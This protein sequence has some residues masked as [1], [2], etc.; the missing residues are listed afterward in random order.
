MGSGHAVS[1]IDS[2][3]GCWRCGVLREEKVTTTD[4]RVTPRERNPRHGEGE[5]RRGSVNINKR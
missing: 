3:E 5:V 1:S 2:P 4:P